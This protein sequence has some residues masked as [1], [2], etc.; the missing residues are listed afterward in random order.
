VPRHEQAQR[1]EEDLE[2]QA[3]GAVLDVPDVELDALVPGKRRAPVD[4]GPAGDPRTHLEPSPLAGRVLIDLGLDRRT[5][6][7]ERH[8][9][10]HDVDEVR[11]LVERQ[12]PDDRPGA[13]DPRIALVDGDARPHG[14]RARDH[15]PQLE[16]LERLPTAPD[17]QLPVDDRTPALEPDRHDG[18]R[19][20]G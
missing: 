6:P 16:H 3:Q 13:R 9:A 20:E 17:A 8:L 5:R 14:L 12:P 18:D 7:D 1:L 15:G 2:V 11:E 10:A 19:Q 4:L